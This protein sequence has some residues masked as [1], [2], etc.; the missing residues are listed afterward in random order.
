M[1]GTQI[2]FQ[3][4]LLLLSLAATFTLIV[5]SFTRRIWPARSFGEWERASATERR[6]WA[7]RRGMVVGT[8]Y[9]VTGVFWILFSDQLVDEMF[10]REELILLAQNWKGVGFVAV[11][12]LLMGWL[13][14]RGLRE[15]VRTQSKLRL[16]EEQFGRVFEHS[17]V[18]MIIVG[19]DGKFQAVNH[20]VCLMLGYAAN[21]LVGMQFTDITHPEDR[22]MCQAEIQLL[23]EGKKE[24]L[25]L[26]KRYLRKDGQVVWVTVTGSVVRDE[27]GQPQYLVG[28]AED[29]TDRRAT[30]KALRQS[31]LK[32]RSLVEQS[33]TGVYIIQHGRF[34]YVNPRICEIFG[35]T[36]L[37]LTELPI[38]NAVFL[39]DRPLVEKQVQRRIL[40][41]AT[42]A[43]YAFRGLRKDSSVIIVEVLGSR[44]EYQGQPAVIGTLID[45]TQQRQA[46]EALRGSE[47]RLRATLENT[48]HVSVQ[49]Y[50]AAGRVVYWNAASEKIFGWRRDEVIGRTLDQFLLSPEN[51]AAF[52][53]V[54]QRVTETNQSQGQ[55][56][57]E[58]NRRDGRPGW[59]L[60]TVFTIPSPQGQTWF[61]CMDVDV[62]EQ[63]LAERALRELSTRLMQTQDEERRR[64]ARE[65]H[66]TTAQQLAALSM[67]LARL[68][69]LGFAAP[70]KINPILD[71]SAALAEQSAQQVR[72][73]TYLLHPPEL[74]SL[75]LPGAIREYAAG[76]ARRSGVRVDVDF[77]PDLGRLPHPVEL[78]LFR[79]VQESLGNILR[80]A[81][82]ETA[83]IKLT[84]TDH[85][86]V[87][88]IQDQG[89]GIPA[90]ALKQIHKHHGGGV[91]LAGM[92]ERL[93][94]LGGQFEI[95]SGPE[96][97]RIR[98][99]V[100]AAEKIA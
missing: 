60:S 59:C 79:V 32:F 42:T 53:A 98:A 49:W 78:A 80:H 63:K 50:D 85:T 16:S 91:G 22:A 24:P 36:Q 55:L 25:L 88:E 58:F 70:E 7:V 97:T 2:I 29:I 10:D 35:Y 6:R 77:A 8:L 13:A 18:G 17:P 45:I 34:A 51:Q 52:L 95:I 9:F 57:Y 90:D 3:D 5:F 19:L 26:E 27:Q 81:Q 92:R 100:P 99:T 28:Q 4:A 14:M 20:A 73:L 48:P 23:L 31:E 71:E 68:K 12:A 67:N 43:H 33:L 66:D 84:R 46:E 21:E 44:T 94:Q 30:Q 74:E 37:E 72:T 39:A 41:Q 62:T 15:V 87:L 83:Q 1:S 82:S 56:E 64:I 89:R 54:L 86:I 11:T 47:E 93:H 69:R 76:L 75:G 38:L 61:V 65:L 96:G 40:D